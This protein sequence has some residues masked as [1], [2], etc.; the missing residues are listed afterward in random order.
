M[1]L[2]EMHAMAKE[3]TN[4]FEK[5]Y[6]FAIMVNNDGREHGH[7]FFDS[8]DKFF[9]EDEQNIAMLNIDNAD[10]EVQ[11]ICLIPVQANLYYYNFDSCNF[12]DM[13]D[14]IESTPGV[15]P[16]P[17]KKE[18]EK[19]NDID[20][21]LAQL[22]AFPCWESSALEHIGYPDFCQYITDT[23]DNEEI[24]DMILHLLERLRDKL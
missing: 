22:M 6:V 2:F 20:T 13:L 24:I 10:W 17:V 1:T 16:Y 9:I 11:V 5:N 8:T 18:K 23:Y 12:T 21:V 14:W 7:I 19:P 15:I 4:D 3:I